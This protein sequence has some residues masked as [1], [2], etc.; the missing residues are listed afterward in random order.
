MISESYDPAARDGQSD[1]FTF[2]IAPDCQSVAASDTALL[3]NVDG[4]A[5]PE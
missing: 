1:S 4:W 2:S 3:A 5:S